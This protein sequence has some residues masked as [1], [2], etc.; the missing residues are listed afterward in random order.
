MHHTIPPGLSQKILDWITFDYVSKYDLTE[1]ATLIQDLPEPLKSKLAL[2]LNE[3]RLHAVPIFHN[4]GSELLSKVALC[5][6]NE[7]F[8]DGVK[9]FTKGEWSSRMVMIVLGTA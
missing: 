7:A 5:L 9:I 6:T 3:N 2:S 4:A 1:T 8:C